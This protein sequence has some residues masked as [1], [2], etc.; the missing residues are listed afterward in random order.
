MT[1]LGYATAADIKT[2]LADCLPCGGMGSDDEWAKCEPCGG[3]GW[4]RIVE[5]VTPSGA[6]TPDTPRPHRIVGSVAT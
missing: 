1:F 2:R 6:L 5:Y 3:K 4:I